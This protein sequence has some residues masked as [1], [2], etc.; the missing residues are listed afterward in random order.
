MATHNA[1]RLIF[2]GSSPISSAERQLQLQRELWKR[3]CQRSLLAWC[4]EALADQ[5]LIP[6]THHRLLIDELEW[7][8]ATPD[9]RL[10]VFMPPGS[11][12]STYATVLFATWWLATRPRSNVIGI[13]YGSELA[14]SFSKRIQNMVRENSRTLGIDLVSENMERWSTSN[15]CEYLAAGAGAAITGF[16]SDL[17]IIDDPVKGR[18]SADS[19]T[20]RDKIWNGYM[21]DIYTRRR[22][23][24]RICLIQTRWHE[25]DFGGRVLASDAANWRIIK[26]P[27]FATSPDDP[28]GRAIDSPLWSDD[29]YGYANDLVT[30]RDYY[31]RNGASRDWQSLYQQEPRPIEG[32]LFKTAKIEVLDVAPNLRGAVLAS[33]WDFGATKKVGTNDPDWTVRVKLARMPSGLYVVLDVFRDR[34]GPDENDNWLANVS[35]Q[36][37]IDHGAVKISLPQ[38]PG[39]AGKSQVLGWTRL[40]AGHTVESSPETGDKATRA[41]PAISQ[42]NGGNFA[43]VRAPWNSVFLDELSAFPSGTKDDQ[44]DALSRAFSLVGLGPPAIQWGKVMGALQR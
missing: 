27:A 31:A 9:A 16:R 11:A 6:A 5:G 38:D 33:G 29:T 15:G 22:P 24:C 40:L 20:M 7:V 37:R 2:D 8:A 12:K 25:N 4:I 30:A 39:Q 21:A 32:A 23:G 43:I 41:A 18:E 36:D 34:G 19:L 28:L 14:A 10:A 26:L 1:A 3:Q 35:N 44:V 42:V 17:V 13:S